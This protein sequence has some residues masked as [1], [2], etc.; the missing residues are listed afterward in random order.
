[1]FDYSSAVHLLL[2]VGM[3]FLS[4]TIFFCLIRAILGPKLTD[5]IVAINVIG[6]KT[7]ILITL[8]GIQIGE[9]YLVDV[10]MVYALLSFLA[11]VVLTRFVLQFKLNK[12]K[13][14]KAKKAHALKG[15]KP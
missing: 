2:L 13:S 10:A 9:S 7:I 4:V 1:M 12:M 15:G 11:V 5:R 3:M 8:V 6:V 14:R